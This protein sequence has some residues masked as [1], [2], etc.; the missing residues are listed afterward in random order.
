VIKGITI[1]SARSTSDRPGDASL[2]VLG[3]PA[4]FSKAEIRVKANCD[5]MLLRYGQRDI[6]GKRRRDGTDRRELMTLREI[7]TAWLAPMPFG[8]MLACKSWNT[9]WFRSIVREL[10]THNARHSELTLW[11]PHLKRLSLGFDYGLVRAVLWVLACRAG[12]LSRLW[13]VVLSSESVHPP[14]RL[15]P[16]LIPASTHG[17]HEN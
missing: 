17:Q 6:F 16:A 10:F 15:A 5:L 3:Q 13:A 11:F 2:S 12:I 8:S 1:N 4:T 9:L 7:N 14:V